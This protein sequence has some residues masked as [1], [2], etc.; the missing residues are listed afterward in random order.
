MNTG[1]LVWIYPVFVEGQRREGQFGV[2]LKR[3]EWP[4]RHWEYYEVY[5]QQEMINCSLRNDMFA[6]QE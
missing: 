2:I 1:Q 6:I 4:N 5:L 3:L